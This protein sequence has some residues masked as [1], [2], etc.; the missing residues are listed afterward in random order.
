MALTHMKPADPEQSPWSFGLSDRL[1]KAMS[2]AGMSNSEMADALDVSRNTIT[3][4]TSG[5]TKP[6]RLQIR[7]WAVRT[8]A[9]LEW[10]ET[11][12]RPV[13]GMKQHGH[14]AITDMFAWRDQRD[15]AAS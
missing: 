7:E 6:S 2:V 3:N 1:A 11:G 14:D 13:N 5:R 4:Y 8:G 10:L 12:E 9:P 15:V